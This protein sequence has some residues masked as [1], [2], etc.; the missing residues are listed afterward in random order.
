MGD[1]PLALSQGWGKGQGPHRKPKS[2]SASGGGDE[3]MPRAQAH[4]QS[5]APQ[6]LPGL[7]VSNVEKSVYLNTHKREHLI[8]G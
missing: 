1:E 3:R 4:V 2:L 5:K 8:Y 6:L 7:R